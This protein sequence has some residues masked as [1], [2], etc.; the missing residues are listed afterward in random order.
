MKMEKGATFVVKEPL[1]TPETATVTAERAVCAN[2]AVARNNDSQI[3]HAIRA[4]DGA[5]GI[6]LS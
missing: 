5:A 2:H 3:V 1:L 4:A 6:W